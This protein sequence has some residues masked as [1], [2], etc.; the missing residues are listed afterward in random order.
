[1][2]IFQDVKSEV[3]SICINTDQGVN[4]AF[5]QVM[6]QRLIDSGVIDEFN[7]CHFDQ[8]IKGQRIK[9]DGYTIDSDYKKVELFISKYDSEIGDLSTKKLER[10]DLSSLQKLAD[11]F[12]DFAVSVSK[13]SYNEDS[14]L[15]QILN[16]IKLSKNKIESLKIHIFADG[17]YTEDFNTYS[18][19]KK[20]SGY[21]YTCELWDATGLRNLITDDGRF[22][23][24]I[25]I[26]MDKY[27]KSV[28][29]L[30]TSSDKSLDTYLATF[31]GDIIAD[32]YNRYG[33]RLLENNVRVFLQSKGKVNKGIK[34]T[35]SSEPEKFI[36]FNNGLSV[37]VEDI[38]FNNVKNG[39]DFFTISKLS[40]LQIVNGGQTT[41]SISESFFKD[42]E[43]DKVRKLSVPVKINLIRDKERKDHLITLISRYSNTQNG[44]KNTDIQ[45][46]HPYH[47]IMEV[48]SKTI[49]GPFGYWIYE[50]LRGSYNQA[51]SNAS[52]KN[53]FRKNNPKSRLLT[54]EYVSLMY[55]CTRGKPQLA[56]N[57]PQKLSLQ[58][59][60]DVSL[61][62]TNKK[63]EFVLPDDHFY[64]MVSAFI[65]FM[66]CMK[67]QKE[68][69]KVNRYN[70]FVSYY[71]VAYVFS[72]P[73]YYFN[74]IKLFNSGEVSNQLDESLIDWL[75]KI[76]DIMETNADAIK[77]D[78]REY[79]KKDTCW[80]KIIK[81]VFVLQR[82]VSGSSGKPPEF[83]DE[84]KKVAVID[85]AIDRCM[86]IKPIIWRRV[87]L[88][89]QEK[90]SK[91]P[92]FQSNLMVCKN[93]YD[94]SSN[95]WKLRP[96]ENIAKIAIDVFDAY[97]A[98]S[99]INL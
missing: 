76:R 47:T 87:I 5:C 97:S 13:S 57:G 58:F 78:Y 44:I 23:N 54:K 25:E 79:Y 4:Q 49:R 55:Y 64:K 15:F 50:R 98:E 18:V 63:K 91:S 61:D 36:A 73:K 30:K 35:I 31:P 11:Q 39:K 3:N 6:A 34:D 59:L 41:A 70:P 17:H 37:T 77:A 88:F 9:I 67:I 46:S 93:I 52:N 86:D 92:K 20:G 32:I 85:D 65:L 53:D 68:I 71:T 96:S 42:E 94:M 2:N 27:N 60:K 82:T 7:A 26:D 14:I 80:E 24:A 29:C 19:K 74:Y 16:D 43:V 45:S 72:H 95:N 33:F 12:Y 51:V 48:K 69:L 66:H 89:L 22:R 28:H 10:R 75:K 81:K 40:G 56:V 84:E 8:T 83:V 21:T 62:F 90:K 38:E 1:M 99:D